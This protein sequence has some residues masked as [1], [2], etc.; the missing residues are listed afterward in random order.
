MGYP[1][2]ITASVTSRS[3]A[4]IFDV[5]V[6]ALLLL[7]GASLINGGTDL[8]AFLLATNYF[9]LG[10][11]CLLATV[12]V[13]IFTIRYRRTPGMAVMDLQVVSA[14]EDTEL[15]SSKIVRRLFAFPISILSPIS[16]LLTHERK[17]V[18]DFISG[19]RVVWGVGIGKTLCYDA[20]GIFR[21]IFTRRG[22]I[23]LVLSLIYSLLTKEDVPNSEL[24]LDAFVV[25]L[26]VA[27]AGALLISGL[28][29]RL[30]RVRVS[31]FGV[32]QS[33]LWRWG[34]VV[35]WEHVEFAQVI[36]RLFLPYVKAHRRKGRAIR[37]PMETGHNQYLADLLHFKNIRIE[38]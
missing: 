32:Q 23:I 18:G 21:V 35:D 27:T 29:T 1:D 17:T 2:L 31:D 37:I 13:L 16:A 30:T 7:A 34:K 10:V 36:P 15:S 28:V 4:W 38:Q 3:F 11:L 5:V 20:G 6:F 33:G 19:T 12:V 26:L 24:V 14:S 9:E 22:L 25:A 8:E